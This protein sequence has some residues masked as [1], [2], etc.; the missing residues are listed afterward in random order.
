MKVWTVSSGD[1]LA[2]KDKDSATMKGMDLRP[3]Y[4]TFATRPEAVKFILDRAAQRVFEA[5]EAL[6][7]AQQRVQKL[8]RKYKAEIS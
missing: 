8:K 4:E 1:V 2:E 3:V 6:R 5:Q 7:A